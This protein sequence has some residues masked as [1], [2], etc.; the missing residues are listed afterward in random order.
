MPGFGRGQVLVLVGRQ[1]QRRRR[2]HFLTCRVYFCVLCLI[3]QGGV[4]VK[5]RKEAT[6]GPII[7]IFL[8][9]RARQR[10]PA[11][12]SRANFMDKH[13]RFLCLRVRF[14]ALL[15]T[16]LAP[17][18]TASPPIK[19]HGRAGQSPLIAAAASS[20]SSSSPN[21]SLAMS[22]GGGGSG[23]H[24]QVSHPRHARPK[25]PDRGGGGGGS[26]KEDCHHPKNDRGWGGAGAVGWGVLGA[27]GSLEKDTAA[28][29]AR[30]GTYDPNVK[31]V[32]NDKGLWVKIRVEPGGGGGR[33]R[34]GGFLLSAVSSEACRREGRTTVKG[35]NMKRERTMACGRKEDKGSAPT[36]R[37]PLLPAL[38]P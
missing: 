21:K 22:S 8:V 4:T 17:P 11:P 37:P 27:F 7:A 26:F 1:R 3:V 6:S 34:G 31:M 19:T 14:T 20:R 15:L 2:Q 36:P 10:P 18:C 16:H 5:L 12:P 25:H 24:K 35:K 23:S 33:G 29:V 9:S 32:K 30:K 28:Q 13:K 38:P